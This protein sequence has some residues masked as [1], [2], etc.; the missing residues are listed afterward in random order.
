M[1]DIK[2]KKK[3]EKLLCGPSPKIRLPP[4]HLPEAVNEE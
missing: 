1:Y 3:L 4:T 2:K